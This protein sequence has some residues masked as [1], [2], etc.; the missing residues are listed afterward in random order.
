MGYW[1]MAQ[2]KHVVDY[3]KITVAKMILKKI[4]FGTHMS[5]VVYEAT[6]PVLVAFQIFFKIFPTLFSSITS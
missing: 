5:I 4:I 3:W 2:K 6:G 1:G